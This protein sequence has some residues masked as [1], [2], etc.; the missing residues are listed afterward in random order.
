MQSEPLQYPQPSKPPSTFPQQFTHW[1]S[2]T[3]TMAYDQPNQRL[4]A[5]IHRTLKAGST[6]H[7]ATIHVTMTRDTQHSARVRAVNTVS[8]A[9]WDIPVG[10]YPP[11]IAEG[12]STEGLLTYLCHLWIATIEQD[13]RT[14]IQRYMGDALYPQRGQVT[15]IDIGRLPEPYQV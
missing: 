12:C 10:A 13:L 9:E 14:S 1:Y 11:S 15:P 4:L 6:T 3:V 5:T 8:D 2:H 7:Q